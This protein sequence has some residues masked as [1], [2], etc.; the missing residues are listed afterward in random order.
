M[1]FHCEIMAGFMVEIHSVFLDPKAAAAAATAPKPLAVS[2][3]E[4]KPED[5]EV[6]SSA[7]T[8]RDIID[9]P[10]SSNKIINLARGQEL[11]NETLTKP[12]DDNFFTDLKMALDD[13]A[14]IFR[15]FME[16]IKAAFKTTR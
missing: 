4:Q 14:R 16:T 15:L 8:V 10:G 11:A 9:V 3:T 2:K 6:N 7:R 13:I 12:V 5:S 1:E